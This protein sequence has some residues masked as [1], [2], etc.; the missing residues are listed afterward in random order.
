MIASNSFSKS[1]TIPLDSGVWL[2]HRTAVLV[3]QELIQKDRLDS[4]NAILITKI[5]TLNEQLNVKDTIIALQRVHIQNNDSI[6]AKLHEKIDITANIAEQYEQRG[7][8][9]K[10]QRN[11][12]I[13]I[14]LVLLVIS[15]TK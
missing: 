10:K 3:A 13:V 7:K 15:I 14:G 12:V 2:N 9:F 11:I 5:D 1:G 4:V 8:K 6:N